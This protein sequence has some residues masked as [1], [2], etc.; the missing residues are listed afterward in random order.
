M[1]CD[2]PE[3]PAVHDQV[4]QDHRLSGELAVDEGTG[5]RRLSRPAAADEL[6]DHATC[7]W[8]QRRCQQRRMESNV[9]STEGS[10]EG[11]AI[12]VPASG[13]MTGLHRFPV[14]TNAGAPMPAR[15][16]LPCVPANQTGTG[17][18]FR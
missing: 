8:K 15:L 13:S 16:R 11:S 2:P 3:P 12:M 7:P 4:G 5:Q 17:V 6:D 9:G 1:V 10:S 14:R 18:A